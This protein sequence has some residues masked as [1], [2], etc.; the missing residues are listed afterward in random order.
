MATYR[1]ITDDVVTYHNFEIHRD[2]RIISPYGRELNP[3]TFTYKNSHVTLRY[4]GKSVKI[5]RAKLIWNAFA[6]NPV[7]DTKELVRFKDGN[8]DNVAFD[9]LFV[10]SRKEYYDD[11]DS[12]KPKTQEEKEM[13]MKDYKKGELSLRQLSHKYDV[14]LRTLKKIVS[15]Q[16]P[17]S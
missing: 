12:R 6:K 7:N 9:N 15:V 3:Y 10:Q 13:I 5:N 17:V 14:S 4:N 1:K 8:P 16:N 11:H 2:G